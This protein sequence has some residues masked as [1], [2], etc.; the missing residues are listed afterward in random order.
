MGVVGVIMIDIS[1]IECLR[2]IT[3]LQTGLV[4]QEARLADEA[5]GSGRIVEAYKNQDDPDAFH[6]SRGRPTANILPFP[7]NRQS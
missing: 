5:I 7:I 2:H 1:D 6:A 3:N 4:L